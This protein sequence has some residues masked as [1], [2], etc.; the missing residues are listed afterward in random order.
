[1]VNITPYKSTQ[2]RNC[3]AQ[4]RGDFQVTSCT[5]GLYNISIKF[6][7]KSKSRHK[8]ILLSREDDY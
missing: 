4:R 5:W 2:A 8:A 7:L 1:M 6:D 3:I